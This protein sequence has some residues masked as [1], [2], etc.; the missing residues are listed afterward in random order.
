M[1]IVS[2]VR[3]LL[4]CGGWEASGLHLSALEV[5]SEQER[6]VDMNRRSFLRAAST[7]LVGIASP[8]W[9]MRNVQAVDGNLVDKNVFLSSTEVFG[10][11]T[12]LDATRLLQKNHP[13][14]PDDFLIGYLVPREQSPFVELDD[15]RD[16][17]D[18]NL[19]ALNAMQGPTA[20]GPTRGPS[21]P[22]ARFRDHPPHNQGVA[23]RRHGFYLTTSLG[24]RI[25]SCD[26][27]ETRRDSF[28]VR[29]SIRVT[30]HDTEEH[31]VHPG[32]IQTIGDYVAVPVVN[33]NGT[34]QVRFLNPDLD[35]PISAFE[36]ESAAF[37]VGVTDVLANDRAIYIAA[38]SAREDGNEIWFYGAQA[39]SLSKCVWSAYPGP[40]C[41]E[42]ADTREWRNQR[43][44][45][46][47]KWHGCK[48]N[49]SLLSDRKGALYLLA[50]GNTEA[51]A[52]GEDYADLFAVDLS[53]GVS[54][55]K[56][57]SVKLRGISSR[58]VYHYGQPSARWGCSARVD[59]A[60]R[61][62]IVSIGY[63]TAGPGVDR[64]EMAQYTVGDCAGG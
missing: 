21:Q 52:Q 41:V 42:T 32:G 9:A 61:V 55:R 14:G 15:E 16:P 50:L 48:N 46:D 62:R 49:L 47:T 29:K 30:D 5:E 11:C 31:Y 10:Q 25:I 39:D 51:Q 13:G 59:R 7:S 18:L 19:S 54:L 2:V 57:A 60:N 45:S 28:H 1:P 26:L 36:T 44:A 37:C 20:A 8:A 17:V 40:W 56:L 58:R 33:E 64:V 12:E 63:A 53:E 43:G 38:V 24:D 3:T 4:P 6:R 34:G 22:G 23:F 35:A 27:H